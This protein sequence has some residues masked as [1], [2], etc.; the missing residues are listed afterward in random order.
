MPI[1]YSRKI[2]AYKVA[3]MANFETKHARNSLEERRL[4]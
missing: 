3:I 1:F 2:L 4:S